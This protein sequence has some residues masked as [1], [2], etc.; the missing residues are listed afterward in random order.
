MALLGWV[1]A[2][3]PDDSWSSL[4][5]TT[6]TQLAAI[7]VVLF[8][9][10]ANLGLEVVKWRTLLAP[11]APSWW[12]CWMGVLSGASLGFISPNRLGEYL[13]R[14]LAVPQADARFVTWSTL[15]SKLGQLV[16]T[17]VCALPAAVMLP[18]MGLSAVATWLV[19]AACIGYLL[20]IGWL[21]LHPGRSLGFL[22]QLAWLA[23]LLPASGHVQQPMLGRVLAYSL[24]RQLVFLLQYALLL[25]AFGIEEPLVILMGYCSW[26]F[27]IKACIPSLAFAEIG[28]RESVALLVMGAAGL[29][30]VPVVQATTAIFFINLALPALIG[31]WATY[32]LGFW[33]R[34][35]NSQA[36]V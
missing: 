5:P 17:M 23:R 9:L 11:Y 16:A 14:S 26:I 12:Q 28:I 15:W 21:W 19:V 20:L 34:Q 30:A 13:A 7:A 35:T 22:A 25:R 2:Q 1:W 29:P 24:L 3:L 6:V 31:G 4:L 32:H 36:V 18:D 33:Q 27:L 10:V 8:L